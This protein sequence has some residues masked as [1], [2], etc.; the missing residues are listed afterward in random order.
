MCT[1]LQSGGHRSVVGLVWHYW[2]PLGYSGYSR[3]TV[4]V[5][6]MFRDVVLWTGRT[7]SRG[8]FA[9]ADY[10]WVLY[11]THKVLT[12]FVRTPPRTECK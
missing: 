9:C 3:N 11:S 6:Q 12:G 10:L 4:S 5:G 7:G 2:V 8:A 1:A